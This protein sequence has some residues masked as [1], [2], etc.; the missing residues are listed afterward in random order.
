M[1]SIPFPDESFDVVLCLHVIAHFAE[2]EQGIKEAF[3]VLKKGGRLM[4]LT[5]NKYFIYLS[6]IMTAIKKTQSGKRFKCDTTAKWLYS[7]GKLRRQLNS[8]AWSSIDYS[9]FQSAPRLLPFE[10]L[11]AKLIAVAT[12]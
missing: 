1:T 4:I 11:R 8:S 10:W 3:R 7:K 9:Y 6:R 5:P 12:K 2:G